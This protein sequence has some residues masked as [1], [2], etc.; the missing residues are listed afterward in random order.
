M[1]TPRRAVEAGHLAEQ[2][3]ERHGGIGRADHGG[4]EHGAPDGDGAVPALGGLVLVC[5]R[6]ASSG[7]RPYSG[8]F[9]TL[10]PS[11]TSVAT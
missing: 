7:L 11:R 4:D 9:R 6:H 2:A 8:R 3:V 1:A 5:V 10:P